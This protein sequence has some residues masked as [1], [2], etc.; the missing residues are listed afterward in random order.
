[1]LG[2]GRLHGVADIMRLEILYDY[3]GI[4]LDADSV[5]VRGLEDWLLEPD[6]FAAWEN[7]WVRPGLIAMGTV[8]AVRKNPFI[9]FAISHLNKRETVLDI[10]PWMVTGPGLITNCARSRPNELTVY[11]SHFFYPEHFSGLKYSGNGPVFARQLWGYLQE[12]VWEQGAGI[13]RVD[14]KLARRHKTPTFFGRPLRPFAR[15]SVPSGKGG[16]L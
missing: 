6:A 8:G 1:M 4:A 3:G 10:P 12:R 16:G 15:E 7:E 11:P 2:A 14:S 5:C 9:A 13:S